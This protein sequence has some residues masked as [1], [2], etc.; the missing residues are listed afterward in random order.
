MEL[1]KLYSNGCYDCQSCG[2][3]GV[4]DCEDFCELDL[5][6]EFIDLMIDEFVDLSTNFDYWVS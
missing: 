4:F 3:N 1:S 2:S 5:M 6:D